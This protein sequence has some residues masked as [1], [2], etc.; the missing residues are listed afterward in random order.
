MAQQAYDA[1]RVSAR[2]G[3]GGGGA[4]ILDIAA[5]LCHKIL[6]FHLFD[7][8]GKLEHL[9]AVMAAKRHDKLVD[10]MCHLLA[11]SFNCAEY[12]V[13]RRRGSGGAARAVPSTSSSSSQHLNLEDP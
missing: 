1:A 11:A 9:S 13:R 2:V 5:V 7:R 10:M 4:H 3:W 8:L 6:H 12:R